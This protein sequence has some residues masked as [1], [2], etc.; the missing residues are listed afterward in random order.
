MMV[1]SI[2]GHILDVFNPYFADGKNNDANILN[3]L[4]KDRNS[5]LLK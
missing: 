4:M 1:V 5:L 2:I 3:S